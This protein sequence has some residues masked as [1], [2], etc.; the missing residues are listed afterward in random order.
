MA[1]MDKLECSTLFSE[2][3]SLHGCEM[4]QG[5]TGVR[6]GSEQAEQSSF[7]GRFC[8]CAMVALIRKE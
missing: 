7:L 1:K 5:A 2:E 6:L 4:Q 3:T 8:G